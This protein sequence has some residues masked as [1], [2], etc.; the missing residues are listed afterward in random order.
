MSVE[1]LI[2]LNGAITIADF[3]NYA[4][5]DKKT[6]YYRVKKPIGKN[7]DFITAPEISSVFGELIA[8]YFLNFI[9]E[10]KKEIAF[11]EMGAGNGTLFF[12]IIET[13]LRI[14]KKLN[15]EEK[16]QKISF[17]IIEISEKLTQ[18]QQEKFQNSNLKIKWHKNFDEFL[19]HNQ[20]RQI[21]FISN[22]LFDCFE[23][24]QFAKTNKKWQEILVSLK[25]EKLTLITEKFNQEKHNF[26]EKIA[27]ENEIDE[28]ANEII[29]EHSFKAQN[30]I[31]QLSSS[32]K[33]QGGIAMIIDYG[34]YNSP[35][36]S[37]LQAI[38]SHEKQ[39]IFQDISNSDLTSLVNFKM[40]EKSAKNNNLQTSLVS[41]AKFL[42]S[43]GIKEKESALLNY[44]TFLDESQVKSA[45]NRLIDKNEMGELFKCL[46]IWD[47]IL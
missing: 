46:I 6:G 3:M 24:H 25:N 18:I 40:L 44:N 7:Q 37:T 17:N 10:S 47:N 36:K 5:F 1:N 19:N 9:I 16:I 33:K 14:A 2:K 28:N 22:E 26:I 29:F 23:I 21:Y 12:D 38:K 41:Q 4:M 31:N 43:L 42:I 11:V 15:I 20:N 35:L 34:Y 39:D 45:I 27:K 13:F 8:I 32:I 30:F